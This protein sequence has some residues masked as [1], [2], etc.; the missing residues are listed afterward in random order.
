[1]KLNQI[2]ALNS[3]KRKR[4]FFFKSVSGKNSQIGHL[5]LIDWIGSLKN[6]SKAARVKI[7][8]NSWKMWT[9]HPH[10][11]EYDELTLYHIDIILKAI[12]QLRV[13]LEVL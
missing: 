13:E 10:I 5:Q 4:I 7:A 6:H 12:I 2:C 1:M 3:F 9:P 11:V 8:V